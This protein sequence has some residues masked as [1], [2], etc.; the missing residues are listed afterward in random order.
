MLS[1]IVYNRLSKKHS[2]TVEGCSKI[3]Y[4]PTLGAGPGVAFELLEPL[5]TD[6]TLHP[7]EQL[8]E[9]RLSEIVLLDRRLQYCNR[10]NIG[11]CLVCALE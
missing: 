10:S 2:E 5:G 4:D 8:P 6:T 7:N 9:K 3:Y 1:V 11:L